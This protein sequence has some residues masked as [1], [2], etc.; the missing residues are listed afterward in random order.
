V[1]GRRPNVVAFQAA[2]HPAALAITEE[3]AGGVPVS[4]NDPA[5]VG[6]LEA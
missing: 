2:G 1:M 5:A 6:D 4:K 3:R